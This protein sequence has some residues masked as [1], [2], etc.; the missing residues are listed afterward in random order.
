MNLSGWLSRAKGIVAAIAPVFALVEAAVTDNTITANEWY[1]I[2]GALIIAAGVY[3]VPNKGYV[4]PLNP[5]VGGTIPPR[6]PKDDEVPFRNPPST[7]SS[8]PL[9]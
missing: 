3:F 9:E 2:V 1:Q 5:A 4:N 7:G 6:P 8:G